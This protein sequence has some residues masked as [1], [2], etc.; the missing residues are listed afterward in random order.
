MRLLHNVYYHLARFY[1]VF[2]RHD[3]AAES[4]RMALAANP[5]FA[6]AASSLGFL[7]ASREHYAE[8][9]AA[10]RQA[11]DINPGNADI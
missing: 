9:G 1:L 6:L 10:F 5:E 11:L 2:K 7:H 4:Y 3:A 8:A